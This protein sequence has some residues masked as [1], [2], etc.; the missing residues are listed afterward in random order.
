MAKPTVTIT[1]TGKYGTGKSIMA[2]EIHNLLRFLGAI[3]TTED[4]SPNTKY[5]A[6]TFYTFPTTKPLEQ[7]SVKIKVE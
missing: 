2:Q 4:A 6:K 1:I 5:K 3:V 7:S